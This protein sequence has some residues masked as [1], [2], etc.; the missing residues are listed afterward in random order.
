METIGSKRSYALT[1]CMPNND[2]DD[3]DSIGSIKLFFRNEKLQVT[4]TD[5][6]EIVTK[7]SN[8]VDRGNIIRSATATC[9]SAPLWLA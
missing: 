2:D 4:N 5:R 6:Y 7:Q 9:P 8:T 3:D 1:W